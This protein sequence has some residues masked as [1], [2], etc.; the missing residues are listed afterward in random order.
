MF[1]FLDRLSRSKYFLGFFIVFLNVGSKFITIRMNDFHERILRDTIG[2]ELMIFAIC[3][4][5]TRDIV[6]AFI[7][8]SVF[9]LLNDYMFN[10]KSAVCIIPKRYRHKMKSAI[11]TNNDDIID[12]SEIKEAIKIL[13]TARKQKQ[14]Q[15]QREVYG[16]F[17][18]NV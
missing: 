6:T 14:Q 8:T 11:D 16:T 9:I 1:E 12:E 17:M 13:N 18:N 4:V 2:R 5:G 10:E 3:F 7:M 15:M